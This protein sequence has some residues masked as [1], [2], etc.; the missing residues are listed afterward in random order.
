MQLYLTLQVG[1]I[2]TVYL[3]IN[4]SK[5]AWESNFMPSSVRQ[6]KAKVLGMKFY[7][8]ELIMECILNIYMAL[9]F[10]D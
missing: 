9:F 10:I 1:L 5:V 4:S 7:L 8:S 6:W 2:S 3:K